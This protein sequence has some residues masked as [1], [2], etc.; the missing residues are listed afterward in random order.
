MRTPAYAGAQKRNSAGYGGGS[1]K[2]AQRFFKWEVTLL[3]A[4]TCLQ[5]PGRAA[6][7]R[8]RRSVAKRGARIRARLER[9]K[10]V[11]PIGW[12]GHQAASAERKPR[13]SAVALAATKTRDWWGRR[14]RPQ[15]INPKTSVQT[16]A[17]GK[18]QFALILPSTPTS[19]MTHQFTLEHHFN[20][21]GRSIKNPIN[22]SRRIQHQFE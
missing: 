12:S 11:R 13:Q 7:G 22:G 9:T 4:R 21:G 8:S 15:N 14:R 3:V 20:K 18:R 1:Q 6:D 19:P 2:M 10:A 5:G 17:S 16:T